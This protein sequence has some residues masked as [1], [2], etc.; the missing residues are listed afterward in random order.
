MKLRDTGKREVELLLNLGRSGV[1]PSDLNN[2]VIDL[3]SAEINQLWDAHI[4]G[5]GTEKIDEL[6]RELTAIRQEVSGPV[7]LAEDW[8]TSD[9]QWWV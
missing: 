8:C 6:Q 7:V 5:E 9:G 4:G 1:H 3:L 2:R